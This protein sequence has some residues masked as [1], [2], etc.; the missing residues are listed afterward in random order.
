M[1]R[2][3]SNTVSPDSVGQTLCRRVR[4]LRHKRNWTLE[5]MAAASGVSRSMLSEI[6]RGAAN[7]TLAVAYRIAQALGLSLGELVEQ[8]GRG[9]HIDVIR[10]D[11]RSFDYRADRQCRIRTLSPL[12]LE[13]SVEFYQITLRCGS[14]LVSQ[15]HFR[16]AC[17]LLSVQRGAVRV[18]CNQEVR[19]LAAG[20]SAHYPADVP[21][22]IENAGEEEAVL[23][24]VVTYTGE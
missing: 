22:A 14:D 16:G 18:R 6:E 15:P 2:R 10:A 7:P 20:D 4:E 17:E 13:K 1:K 8:P 12:H 9:S 21:H 11:D 19:E 3:S 23:Y 5:Q 24:L